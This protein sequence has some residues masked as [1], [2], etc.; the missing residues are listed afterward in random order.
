MRTSADEV[1][2]HALSPESTF[3][4][5]SARAS[6]ERHHAEPDTGGAR[7]VR[8]ADAP[9]ARDPRI[10]ARSPGEQHPERHRAAEVADDD[11]EQLHAALETEPTPLATVA[12]PLQ[13]AVGEETDRRTHAEQPRHRPERPLRRRIRRRGASDAA[14]IDAPSSA[15]S[16]APT[17]DRCSPRT[18]VASRQ[19]A[20]PKRRSG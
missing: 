16:A 5:S 11:E 19:I 15:A 4:A 13:Q 1:S 12:P 6:E 17:S 9:A 20:W 18:S 7:H 10:D 14:L 8:G 3:A 2:I